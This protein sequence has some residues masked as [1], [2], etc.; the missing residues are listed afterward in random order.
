MRMQAWVFAIVI[1]LFGASLPAAASDLSYNYAELRFV[2]TEIGSQ[3]GD[4]LRIAGSFELAQNWLIVG[5]YTALDFD[6][7]VDTGVLEIGGGYVHRY[8][9]KLDIVG[10]AKLVRTDIDFPGGD[11]NDTGI[12]LAGGVRGRISPQFEARATINYFN[13]DETDTFFE[14]G[15]DF[16]ITNQFA[17]GATLEF[18]GDADSLTV[19]VRWFF[20]N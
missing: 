15:G 12:A 10:Y 7:N 18:G 8:S 9:P 19:G 16:Y 1:G 2:D 20:G 13:V 14:V 6:N 3:D 5:G 11:D 4:G 17:A